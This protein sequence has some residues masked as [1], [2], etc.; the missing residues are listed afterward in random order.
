MQLQ[1]PSFLIHQGKHTQTHA[2]GGTVSGLALEDHLNQTAPDFLNRKFWEL[3]LEIRF[4]NQTSRLATKS[5]NHSKFRNGCSRKTLLGHLFKCRG[6]WKKLLTLNLRKQGHRNKKESDV[7]SRIRKVPGRMPPRKKQE[8]VP[9]EEKEPGKTLGH[10]RLGSLITLAILFPWILPPRSRCSRDSHYGTLTSVPS[11]Q[12]GRGERVLGT[13]Q[14][15]PPLTASLAE[16]GPVPRGLSRDWNCSHCGPTLPTPGSP[17]SC[18]PRSPE[19]GEEPQEAS[20]ER[21]CPLLQWLKHVPKVV[22]TYNL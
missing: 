3:H 6:A 16:Q 13:A 7:L 4:G 19:K 18:Q 8:T 17:A 9:R 14:A 5:G 20:Q 10:C 11:L 15:G 2:F 21:P 12:E 22:S 1:K